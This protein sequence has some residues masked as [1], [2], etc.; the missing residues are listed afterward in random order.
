[1]INSTGKIFDQVSEDFILILF[2]DS[3]ADSDFVYS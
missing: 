2:F 3:V 1:M